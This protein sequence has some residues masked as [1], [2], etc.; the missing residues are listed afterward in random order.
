MC[1]PQV[2]VTFNFLEIRAMNTYAEHQVTPA[3][4]DHSA[5]RASLH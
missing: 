5:A 3:R 2:E 1:R 4:L